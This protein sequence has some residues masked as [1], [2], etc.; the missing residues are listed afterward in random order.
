MLRKKLGDFLKKLF[1]KY[2]FSTQSFAQDG[3]DVLLYS[4]YKYKKRGHKGFYV[5]IGAHHP[6][7]F[8]NTALFY[9]KGWTGINLEPTPHLIK[10]FRKYRRK[11][12]NLE[13]AV[14]DVKGKLSFFE[15]NEPAINGFD[16]KLSLERSKM[17]QYQLIAQK[18]IPVMPLSE[19]LDKYLPQGQAIDFFSIDVEGHDINILRSND[20]E[21]YKP[22]FILIEGSLKAESLDGKEINDFLQNKGYCIAGMAK[23]TLLYR[24][25]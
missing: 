17:P 8:S 19:I 6:F 9:A 24:L 25:A 18:E 11:D 13:L 7:R 20:W 3:E 5:D 1:P 16:E 21:K 10:L 15:F 12:I 2:M 22:E 14:S 4:F 23:R